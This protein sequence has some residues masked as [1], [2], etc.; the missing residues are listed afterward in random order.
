MYMTFI[1]TFLSGA[2]TEYLRV[3]LPVF[4]L[5]PLRR[6]HRVDSR[7]L[8]KC[9]QWSRTVRV[10][11]VLLCEGEVVANGMHPLGDVM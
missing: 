6:V 11:L 1:L 3:Y 7:L 4:T 10:H 5:R 9:S 2:R 8:G